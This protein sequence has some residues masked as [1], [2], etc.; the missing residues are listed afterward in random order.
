M[1]D[2]FSGMLQQCCNLVTTFIGN[3]LQSV[4]AGLLSSCVNSSVSWQVQDL[5]AD[6]NAKRDGGTN[7]TCMLVIR[8]NSVRSDLQRSL[9]LSRERNTN[10]AVRYPYNSRFRI[11]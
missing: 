8:S 2:S 11:R 10:D 6:N 7:Q 5:R 3:G 4:P 9:L 1:F